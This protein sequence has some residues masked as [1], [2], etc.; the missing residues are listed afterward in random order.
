MAQPC[1]E[2]VDV[3]EQVE[4]EVRQPKSS[5]CSLKSAYVVWQSSCHALV[6]KHLEWAKRHCSGINHTFQSSK[7][8]LEFSILGRADEVI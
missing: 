7:L 6:L 5:L 2:D 4:V 3:R 1:N 8:T